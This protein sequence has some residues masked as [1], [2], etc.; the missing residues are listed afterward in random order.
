[1]YALWKSSKEKKEIEKEPGSL[2]KE[3]MAG[4]PPIQGKEMD[5]Q[6]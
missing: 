2:F 3:I 1:M 5:I 6:L 4:N